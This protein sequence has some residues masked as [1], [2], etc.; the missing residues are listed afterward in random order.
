MFKNRKA[1]QLVEFL[2]VAPFIVIFLGVLTEYAYALNCN[3]TL[4]QGLKEVTSTVYREIVPNISDDAVRNYVKNE[5]TSYL[6]SNNVPIGGDYSVDVGYYPGSSPT[7]NAVFVASYNY[8]S[9]FTLPNVFF[10]ILPEKFTFTATSSVPAAFL[11]SNAYGNSIS[12]TQLDKIW[13]N[14]ADFSS[15]DSFNSLKRGI[16]NLTPNVSLNPSTAIIFLV[17][18]AIAVDPPGNYYALVYWS[19]S[20]IE[21]RVLKLADGYLYTC[22]AVGCNKE[23]TLLSTYPGTYNFI[24]IPKTD[25]E[26][27]SAGTDATKLKSYW[28]HVKDSCNTNAPKPCVDTSNA[29]SDKTVDGI[30]KRALAIVDPNLS[31]SMGNYDNIDVY[32]YNP[33][34]AG[35]KSYQLDTFGSIVFVH[36]VTESIS[37]LINGFAPVNASR[38][39]IDPKEFGT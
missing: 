36:P 28:V 39:D 6:Q 14:P 15:L 25:P 27:T 12:S 19:G 8:T 30:L 16:M 13:G 34:A 10:H 4:S 2:L 26:L 7:A 35:S 1:Q 20:K 18:T 23:S 24:F 5:L 22:D 29:V 33:S 3:L 17:P 38:S 32:P 21:N 31:R 37:G 11:S 9:A